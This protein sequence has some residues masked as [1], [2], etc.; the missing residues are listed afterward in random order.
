MPIRATITVDI[1]RSISSGD[2]MRHG[3]VLFI[4]WPVVGSRL[5]RKTSNRFIPIPILPRSTWWLG[6]QSICHHLVITDLELNFIFKATLIE[7][8]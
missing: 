3:L 6:I 2:M 5:I 8:G 7:T 4:S 1:Y